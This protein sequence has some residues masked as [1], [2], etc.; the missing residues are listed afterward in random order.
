M[1]INAWMLDSTACDWEDTHHTQ[2]GFIKREEEGQRKPT[3]DGEEQE[4]R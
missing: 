4:M 2:W 3:R 1:Q